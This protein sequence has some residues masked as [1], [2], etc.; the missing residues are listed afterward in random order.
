MERA[1]TRVPSRRTI[2]ATAALALA[3][4]CPAR[5]LGRPEMV[6]S[7]GGT[8]RPITIP[9]GKP[10]PP[11]VPVGLGAYE[12][13]ALWPRQRIGV[14]A[15]MRSTRDPDGLN[16]T[17]DAE[18]IS[19]PSSSPM[20]FWCSA[21][22]ASSRRERESFCRLRQQPLLMEG[23]MGQHR[24]RCGIATAFIFSPL[25]SSASLAAD[26]G[27]ITRASSHGARETVDRFENAVK[28]KGWIVFSEIDHAGAAKQVGIDMKPRTVILFGNPKIGTAPMQKAA[29]LAIDNPPKALVWEDEGGKV[30]LT[31][32]SAE[33]IGQGIYPRHGVSMPPEAIK[34]IEQLLTDVSDAATK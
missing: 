32:N 24:N 6:T 23:P 10:W 1:R 16:R 30:W 26:A 27:L 19:P 7:H 12:H 22:G 25:L 15:Y 29:T 28:S 5:D 9:A 31:Y 13:W 17:A 4:R 34:D 11:T 14:R 3:G 33:Y 20:T 21:I 8:G 2:L 18:R